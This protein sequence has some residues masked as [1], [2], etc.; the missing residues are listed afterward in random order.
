MSAND[1][2]PI[3]SIQIN[4][5]DAALTTLLRVSEGAYVNL[6]VQKT[7]RQQGR[8]LRAEKNLYTELAYGC[9]RWQLYLDHFLSR[10]SSQ[11]LDHLEAPVLAAIRL[12]LY[13]IRFLSGIPNHA[14]VAASCEALKR[15]LPRA[16]GY[17]NAVLRKAVQEQ[18]WR[19]DAEP[20]SPRWLSIAYSH[21]QWMV[22]RWLKRWGREE[23]ERLLERNNQIPPTWMRVNGLKTK[24]DAFF[25]ALR[26]K[27]IDFERIESLPEAFRLVDTPVEALKEEMAEGLISVQDVGAMVMAHALQPQAG[28]RVLD[29]CAAPGGK[30]CQIAELM[31]NQGHIL[32]VDLHEARCRLIE[33]QALR[34]GI[35][36]IET[37]CQDARE[38]DASPIYDRVLL[39]APCSGTG[40]LRRKVDARWQKSADQFAE[41]QLLQRQLLDA[42]ARTLKPGGILL[43]STCS[44]E[45]EE[46]E[47]N[48]RWFLAKYPAFALVPFPD[49]PALQ[50]LSG[51]DLGLA[52][53]NGSFGDSDGFFLALLQLRQDS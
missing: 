2:R 52:T 44:L 43:Y 33:G 37:R 32:A 23:T 17:A 16:V 4:A 30:S 24:Q 19:I 28:M 9:V 35:G 7:L 46:N 36:I 12:G 40:V 25:Q 38:L 49:H 41:L 20:G 53:V 3:K 34:L 10:W 48:I 27:E 21:P 39:D 26:D 14:A 31:E 1:D 42:A 45:A 6:E 18:D 50:S 51:A 13:Q 22:E 8:W 47:A 11:E 29:L 15:L 5:R